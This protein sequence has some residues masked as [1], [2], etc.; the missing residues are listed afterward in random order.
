MV[1]GFDHVQVEKMQFQIVFHNN[2]RK[3]K[4]RNREYMNYIFLIFFLSPS[5]RHGPKNS[6]FFSFTVVLISAERS[7]QHQHSLFAHPKSRDTDEN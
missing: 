6:F 7:S 1:H 4:P 2:Y 5:W 3:Y